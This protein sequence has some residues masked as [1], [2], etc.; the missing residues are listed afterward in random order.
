MNVLHANY[1]CQWLSN[2]EKSME[3]YSVLHAGGT[4]GRAASIDGAD[5]ARTGDATASAAGGALQPDRSPRL[6]DWPVAA[7][8]KGK[9]YRPHTDI[10]LSR[11]HRV[12]A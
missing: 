6:P 7:S 4:P 10:T 11:W 1:V 8:H 12:Y 2:M 5:T 3:L 9:L